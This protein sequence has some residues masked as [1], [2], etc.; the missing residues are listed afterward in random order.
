M[1]SGA[2]NFQQ[3]TAFKTLLYTLI[4]QILFRQE[5]CV[6]VRS[7]SVLYNEYHTSFLFSILMK[8]VDL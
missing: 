2:E 3:T 8:E 4:Q 7:T 5:T 6:F 1:L